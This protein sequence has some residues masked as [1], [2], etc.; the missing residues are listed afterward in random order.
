MYSAQETP[1]EKFPQICNFQKAKLLGC[2][3]QAKQWLQ[4]LYLSL[5]LD[6]NNFLN[7]YNVHFSAQ[8][9]P[10]ENIPTDLQLEKAKLLCCFRQAKQWH[11]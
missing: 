11:L 10:G 1:R 4:Y 8:E 5:L 2:F 3:R 7:Y 9:T 6:Q